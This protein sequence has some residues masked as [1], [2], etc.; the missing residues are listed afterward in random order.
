MAVPIL[1]QVRV[2][3]PHRA[4]K[5]GDSS[6]IPS[7]SITWEELGVLD[8]G[9]HINWTGAFSTDKIEVRVRFVDKEGEMSNRFPSWSSAVTIDQIPRGNT[10][11][12]SSRSSI[13]SQMRVVDAA[14]LP[15]NVSVAV[16]GPNDDS[17]GHDSIRECADEFP[18]AVRVVS[19]F[20]PYW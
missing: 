5:L 10:R 9:Q 2:K 3:N 15:L 4:V 17:T 20:V 16:E 7:N 18:P 12:S 11:S 13:V 1:V 6:P 19:L 14:N 8:C